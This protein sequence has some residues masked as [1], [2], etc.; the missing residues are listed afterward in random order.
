[1]TIVQTAPEAIQEKLQPLSDGSFRFACHPAVPCFTDCCRDLRL[2]L[3]PYDILRLKT[4]LQ[5][6]AGAFLEGYGESRFDDQRNLPMVYLKMLEDDRRVCPFVSRDGCRVYED[7]PAACRIYPIAQATR[8]HRVHQT[9]L[10]QYFLLREDHC[11]GFEQHRLW[12][13]GDWLKDQGLEPYQEWNNLW[14][15]LITHPRLHAAPPLSTRQ[16]QM[17]FLACYNLDKFR[18]FVFESRFLTAFEITEEMGEVLRQNDEA[19]LKLAFSW[20][21]F[22]LFNEPTLKVCQP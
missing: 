20:I 7:R 6:A 18:D 16:H 11:R 12:A 8:R 3:T 15:D 22:S 19:L 2:L 21:R 9:V 10:E 13:I 14:M 17:F 5:M 4:H 1:M